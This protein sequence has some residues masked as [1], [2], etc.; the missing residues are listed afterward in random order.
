LKHEA[1]RE[2]LRAA[3]RNSQQAG[4]SPDQ[5]YQELHAKYGSESEP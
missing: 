4:L 5:V 2:K 3:Y 1:I